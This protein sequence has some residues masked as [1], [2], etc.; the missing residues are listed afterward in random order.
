[1]GQT[2]PEQMEIPIPVVPAI[3]R[4]HVAARL[5]R[6]R[7]TTYAY[8]DG[9]CLLNPGGAGGWAWVVLGERQGFGGVPTTTSQRMELTAALQA[10]Q[11]LP[12]PLVVVTDSQYVV[13][14]FAKWWWRAWEHR[15]RLVEGHPK[16]VANVDLWLPLLAEYHAGDFGFE[17]VR[18]HN[19]S[20]GNE[21]AD[22]LARREA[23]RADRLSRPVTPQ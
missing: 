11:S 8:S 19:G 3:L 7:S 23:I 5:V 15:G 4:D 12:R 16:P 6:D 22:R 10:A 9:S 18:G 13:N 17:W 20:E 2:Q 21:A 14:C 1:M